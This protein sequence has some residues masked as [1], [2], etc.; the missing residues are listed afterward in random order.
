MGSTNGS[1]YVYI[2]GN[3]FSYGCGTS[4]APNNCVAISNSGNHIFEQNNDFSHFGIVVEMY[5]QYEVAR[6]NFF[7]DIYE[8]ECGSASGN[9]HM[10]M[11]YAER[12]NTA[13]NYVV[14]YQLWE[15]NVATNVVGVDGKGLWTA[16][17]NPSGCGTSCFN[18]IGRYNVFSHFGSAT[19]AQTSG[20]LNVK[21]YNNTWVDPNNGALASPASTDYR[22]SGTGGAEINNLF[23]YPQSV[24]QSW[25]W[26]AYP[27]PSGSATGFTA[28]ANLAYCSA[29]PCGIQT[30]RGG[31]SYLFAADTPVIVANILD[32]SDPLANYSG[33]NYN[34]A[35]GS[36]ALNAG[37]Y[38]TTVASGD[39]GSGTS[40]VV[41]D[42]G[43][44]Q[45]GLGL[46]SAGVQADCISVTTV[47]NHI[48]ISAVNYSTNTL[49]MAS[50]FSRSV[51]DHIWLYSKSDG[52][53]VLT[54]S[55]P[56]IG[57]LGQ[58]GIS[59]TL[60]GAC[61]ACFN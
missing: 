47:S 43:F 41:T 5:G 12:S 17:D 44:F 28:G 56:N 1:S 60:T 6:N 9:C 11:L 25:G 52:T 49:T 35:S 7:H 19:A 55:A 14:Q 23:Y 46:T 20:F 53:Q 36:A 15:N 10:D 30:Q 33:G 39:S 57:A 4:S 13:A 50:G 2:T 22:D 27:V 3:T 59:N 48:C 54:G 40:L 18:V 31:T 32:T 21:Y 51:G 16:A 45:D 34:L 61:G 58:G 26:Y 38:L 24:P 37:T 42:A 8:S 29:T